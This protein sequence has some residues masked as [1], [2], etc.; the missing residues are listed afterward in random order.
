MAMD[1]RASDADTD[2]LGQVPLVER[3]CPLCGAD[4]AGVLPGPY[5]RGIWA[6]KTCAGCGF[7]YCDTAPDTSL[8]AAELAWERT[9]KQED[10]RRAAERP[11][12]YPAS[13][14]TR[15]RLHLL[16]R[17]KM[18]RMVAANARPGRVIDLGCGDGAAMAPLASDYVPFGI[19]I[20]SA[21]CAVADARFARRGGGAINAPC[22]DG[23]ADFP[24][25]HFSAAT[26]RSYLEHEP[27]PVP[28]LL[29]LHRTLEP[30]AVALVKV[31]NYGSLNRRVM[32]A[33]WCGFRTPDHLNY[34]T[35]ASL[36]AMAE[37]CGYRMRCGPADRL[38]TSDNLYA[39]LV[40]S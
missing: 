2:G 12:S 13:R 26:L 15:A 1:Q 4:N 11:L 39:V 16:P 38:P 40:K 37:R 23:L 36:R 14:L 6:I 9:S 24:D 5:S 7:V 27:N 29:A 34:F 20:S 21:A 33:K 31:P 19:E 22:L 3:P 30:G 8:L 28:V 10:R 32:G 35:P 18:H 25:G 17:K